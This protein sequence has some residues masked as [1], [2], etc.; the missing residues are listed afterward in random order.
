M[1]TRGSAAVLGRDDT[2]QLAVGKA[3]DLFLLDVDSIDQVGALL[4]PGCFLGTVGYAR[5]CKAVVVGGRVVVEDGRLTGID[6]PTVREQAQRCME[7]F[8]ERA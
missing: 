7:Q 4:D 8:L 2:G 1:A 6:E 5:P 3:G